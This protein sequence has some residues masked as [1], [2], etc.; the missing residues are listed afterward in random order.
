MSLKALPIKKKNNREN[1]FLKSLKSFGEMWI[2]TQI[3]NN[4]HKNKD[5]KK[6]LSHF[7]PFF[8][9]S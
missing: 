1:D 4:N 7:L 2:A 6:F 9:A 3:Y 8:E 5:M